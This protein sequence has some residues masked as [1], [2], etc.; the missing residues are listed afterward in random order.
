MPYTADDNANNT[1]TVD[2]KLAGAYGLDQL[3][4]GRRHT[5]S[6]YTDTITGLTSGASYEVRLTYNDPDSVIGLNPQISAPIVWTDMEN[7]TAYD[8]GTLTKTA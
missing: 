6:P 4:H 2:Y 1:Y 3:D 7:V 8:G 5:A